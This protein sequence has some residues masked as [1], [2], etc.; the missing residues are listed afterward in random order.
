MIWPPVGLDLHHREPALVGAVGA[1]PE[2][3][4]DPGESRRTGQHLLG[5]A[6][7]P[8]VLTSAATSATA[9]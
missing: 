8:W 4:V 9:S 7:R 1:E 5:E 6:L 3:P 2:Q